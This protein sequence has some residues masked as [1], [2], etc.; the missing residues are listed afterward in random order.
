MTEQLTR[1]SVIRPMAADSTVAARPEHYRAK[2]PNV[3]YI[4]LDDV[5]FGHLGCYGST[6]RTP[7]LDQL[8]A[9]GI[10]YSNFHTTPMCSPTRACLLTGRNHHAVGM[11][12]IAEWSNDFDNSSGQ[13]SHSAMTVAELLREDGY[14]TIAVG[15]WHVD[16]PK[17]DSAAGP[18]D[19]WPLGRGFDHYYGF[20]GAATDQF[21]PDLTEDNHHITLEERGRPDD[22]HLTN[23]LID[24][25]IEYVRSQQSA[26]QGKPF[27]L[28]LAMG[29]C[30]SPIQVPQSDRKSVV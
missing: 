30:H 19:G 12:G 4:V 20:L 9:N 10:R 15:K 1:Q 2:R 25:S 14:N 3:V 7:Q 22:Y 18:F 5:G 24:R 28:Y 16:S 17:H 29:A 23:D 11:G 27:F 13:I 26:G 21:H 8:A 6:I